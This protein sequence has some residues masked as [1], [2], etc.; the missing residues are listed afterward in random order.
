MKGIFITFEGGEGSGK[1]TIIE[2]L[3]NKLQELGYEVIKTREPGGVEIS[4]EIRKII[5]D[6]KNTKMSYE[7]EA[8]LYAACRMQHLKEK[9]IP[10]LVEGKVVICDRY[11]DSSLVYQGFARHLGID[12]VLKANYF[13][14][15]HMPDLTFFI[16]VRPEVGL[17]RIQNRQKI[18]RLDMEKL[19]FHND[20]YDGYLKLLK[21]YPNRIIRIDGEKEADKV[22]KSVIDKTIEYLNK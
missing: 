7:T 5:L 19:S 4:E 6:P 15:N 3:Y 1:T 8:L 21:L 10:A 17:K 22:S 11:I 14:L 13:A 18:D 16:D 20:V 2:S 9:V 12:D